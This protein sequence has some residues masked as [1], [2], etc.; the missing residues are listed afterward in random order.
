MKSE[1]V[2]LLM[3]WTWGADHEAPPRDADMRI[4]AIYTD[5]PH[6]LAMDLESARRAFKIERRRT[7]N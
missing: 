2:A 1:D 5:R 4:R 7:A 3:W 6:V